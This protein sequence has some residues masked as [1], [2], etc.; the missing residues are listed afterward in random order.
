MDTFFQYLK[1]NKRAREILT[2]EN[3]AFTVSKIIALALRQDM[4]IDKAM[5][6]T[7]KQVTSPKAFDPNHVS[8]IPKDLFKFKEVSDLYSLSKNPNTADYETNDSLEKLRLRKA[9]KFQRRSKYHLREAPLEIDP[10]DI[11]WRN[12]ELLTKFMSPSGLIKHNMNSR[13][14][15]TVHKK[16]RN[17]I[18]ES[19]RMGLL[20][21]MGFL[22]PHHRLS[23]KSLAEDITRDANMNIDLQTGALGYV[24][25]DDTYD[26][27]RDHF[28]VSLDHHSVYEGFND[29]DDINNPAVQKMIFT[30]I[31]NPNSTKPKK[32]QMTEQDEVQEESDLLGNQPMPAELAE[33]S[34]FELASLYSK[35]K[36]RKQL[37]ERGV[38]ISA[39]D[40]EKKFT[41]MASGIA[42][43]PLDNIDENI[44][45]NSPYFKESHSKMIDQFK[46]VSEMDMLDLL[47]AESIRDERSLQNI[48]ELGKIVCDES[49]ALMNVSYKEI[50]EQ[51]DTL[52]QRIPVVQ[53]RGY[54]GDPE[55][56]QSEQRYDGWNNADSERE[57]VTNILNKFKATNKHGKTE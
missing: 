11:H 53:N 7:G 20:P 24:D 27:K 42:D 52:K 2:G 9:P 39:L 40:S 28:T 6:G 35:F 18:R 21:S 19:R 10:N 54:Q 13:L 31:P 29:G 34:S 55:S 23:L 45:E 3:N 22:K 17:A 49:P 33:M 4:G 14:P 41:L 46:N 37:K 32:Y 12:T 50:L 44:F 43:A 15:R 16:I 26:Y 8:G 47:V 5:S 30:R 36:K 56:K 1:T 57:F 51:L 38:N 48:N 25:D